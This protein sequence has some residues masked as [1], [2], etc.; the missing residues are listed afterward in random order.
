MH[1]HDSSPPDKSDREIVTGTSRRYPQM[2]VFSN[3][4]ID[5]PQD[6][7]RYAGA[8]LELLADQDPVTVLRRTPAAVAEATAGLTPAQVRMSE[9]PGSNTWLT[10][11][12]CGDGASG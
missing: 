12:S 3:R 6:R 7:A 11:I 8:I 2:S 10:P 9:A 1:V 4:S 5:P